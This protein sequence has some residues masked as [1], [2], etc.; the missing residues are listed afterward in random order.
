[1][2]S[3]FQLLIKAAGQPGAVLQQTYMAEQRLDVRDLS[4]RV[5]IQ[6]R[7]QDISPYRHT[8][9]LDGTAYDILNVIRLH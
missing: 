7:A 3:K 4:T 2:T 8:L 5:T 1:M 6:I 9:F